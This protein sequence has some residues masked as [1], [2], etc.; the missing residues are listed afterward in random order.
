MLTFVDLGTL[1]PIM[2]AEYLASTEQRVLLRRV[3]F[4]E[5]E[6]KKEDQSFRNIQ[7][8]IDLIFRPSNLYGLSLENPASAQ[9]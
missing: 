8:T 9:Q 4:S 5:F 6:L 7:S 1:D 3:T 2:W